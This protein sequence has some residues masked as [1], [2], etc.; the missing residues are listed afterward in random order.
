M[1]DKIMELDFEIKKF[2]NPVEEYY[3]Y[4]KDDYYPEYNDFGDEY[5]K[6]PEPIQGTEEPVIEAVRNLKHKYRN[7]REY[8]EAMNIYDEYAEWLV[9]KYGGDKGFEFAVLTGTCTE[10]IPEM[11]ILRMTKTN[12]EIINEGMMVYEIPEEHLP[13]V[14][15]SYLDE[16]D[17]IDERGYLKFEIEFGDCKKKVDKYITR[18]LTK[19][20]GIKKLATN[21]ADIKSELNYMDKFFRGRINDK[22]N[23]RDYSR[24]MAALRYS[25][26]VEQCECEK[27]MS[28]YLTEAE[29]TIESM[30]FGEPLEE[31][32]DYIVF[33]KGVYI[34]R[35]QLE[36]INVLD[37]INEMGL[38]SSGIDSSRLLNKKTLKVVRKK[39]KK[40]RKR[41]KERK[42]K[43]KK[44]D[45][46]RAATN[47]I[48]GYEANS[49]EELERE[50]SNFTKEDLL[51]NVPD[52][53]VKF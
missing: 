6:N 51:K 2:P 29:E 20:N 33:Y 24:K 47:S 45:A 19:G 41:D 36:A 8:N 3:D 44:R 53:K 37:S 28:D 17:G 11:P 32:K 18:R 34:G 30:K 9:D 52:T 31:N 26:G 40:K 42:K 35:D 7:Y 46:F 10:P 16:N 4:T 49:Y 23:V 50:L 38:S 48:W 14:K 21:F 15:T 13:E 5:S 43:M 1:V 22:T 27:T 39:E 12:K 25:K